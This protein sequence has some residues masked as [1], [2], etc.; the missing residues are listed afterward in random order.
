MWRFESN[1]NEV[2]GCGGT[3]G[4]GDGSADGHVGAEQATL[5]NHTEQPLK[6]PQLDDARMILP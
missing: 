3:N 2:V 1:W 4:F 5:V 6:R